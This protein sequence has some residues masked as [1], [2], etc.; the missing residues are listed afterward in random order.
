MTRRL[1]PIVLAAF[2]IAPAIAQR[3]LV[4]PTSPQRGVV[5][6][7]ADLYF[8]ERF[9]WQH[10]RP[11][12]AGMNAGLVKEAVQLA[13]AAETPGP[14]DMTLFLHSSFGKEP[15]NTLVG[16]V[17]DRGPASGLRSGAHCP[18]RS[19]GRP[20]SRCR[21]PRSASSASRRS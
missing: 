17:K 12:D 19:S 8:P 4:S 9:D 3:P 15:Y 14:K 21:A 11:E 5:A 1:L 20:R 7:P 16:P 18:G 13:V 2:V 10:K 6:K